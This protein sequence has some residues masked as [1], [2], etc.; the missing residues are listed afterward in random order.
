MR[1]R[2]FGRCG[3]EVSELT[4]GTWG[5]SGDGYGQVFYK[6]VDRVID[7][8]VEAGIDLFD[9]ADVYGNGAIETKLGER[10]DSKETK[11]ITKIGTF[12]DGDNASKRFDEKSL[13]E[14]FDKSQERLKRDKLDIVLLHCPS[15]TALEAGEGCEFLKQKVK[16][17][18]LRAWGVSAGS[19]EVASGAIDVG[20]D[21][22]MLAYNMFVARDLHL[23]TDLVEATETA[24]LARS[25]LSHGLLCGYWG[26]QKSFAPYDHRSKRWNKEELVYRIKQLDAVRNLISEDVPNLRAAALRFVLSNNLVTSAVVGPRAVI[27]L[28]QL[29]REMGEGPDYLSEEQLMELPGHLRE[30][31]IML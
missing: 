8:A 4:I 18:K 6:E 15:L 31:G 14:A 7:R 11:V 9:T 13:S 30:V 22:V 5:L 19:M 20:C 23:M 27:H 12:R 21:V 10:L 26:F 25:V 3:F 16:D 17:D 28:E 1:K 24:V 29:L 2:A